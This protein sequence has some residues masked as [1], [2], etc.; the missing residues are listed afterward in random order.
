MS[1]DHLAFLPGM[2]EKLGY[3]VYA[4]RDPRDK[5]I[6]YVGKG[7]GNRVYQHAIQARVVDPAEGR[8][9]LKLD[10]IRAI[11]LGGMEVEVEILRHGLTDKEAYTAEAVAIDALR[12]AGLELTNLSRGH[13]SRAMGWAPL[14]EL[15][16]RY[17]AK[18]A[19]FDA[20]HR[21]VLIRINRNYKP[22]LADADL[23]R[24]TRQWWVMRPSRRPELAFSVYHGIARA[25]FRI[26][27]DS[28][29]RHENGRW[30]FAG[31]RDPEMEELYAWCD[32]SSLLPDGAQNPI[33]Y[34]NC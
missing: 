27:P 26:D 20:G 1:V 14:E 4:L 11:H 30:R 28:W 25:V 33:R 3:Y 13:G 6:F 8:K 24:F 17:A 22:G 21:I 29:E 34:V 2:T 15:R 5:T 10:T 9:G 23:Y 7:A 31:H 19:V 18:P 32:V 12:A 16:A